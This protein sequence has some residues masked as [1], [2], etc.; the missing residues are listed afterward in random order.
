[1]GFGFI[2]LLIVTPLICAGIALLVLLFMVLIKANRLLGIKLKK[3]EAD[4][5]VQPPQ[6]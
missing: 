2:N 5:Y 6:Q 3:E 1:M 4:N